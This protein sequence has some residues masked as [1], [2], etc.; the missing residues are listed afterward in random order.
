MRGSSVSDLAPVNNDIDVLWGGVEDI[1][2]RIRRVNF[3]VGMV[4]KVERSLAGRCTQKEKEQ[5]KVG[6]VHQRH[7]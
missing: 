4:E 7:C 5:G 2:N 1:R 3:E 6:R